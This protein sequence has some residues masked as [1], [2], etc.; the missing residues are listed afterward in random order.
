MQKSG[1]LDTMADIIVDTMGALL[2]SIIG[3]LYAKGN[4]KFL[5]F[6][7]EDFIKA[8]PQIFRKT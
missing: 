6:F 5:R 2:I 4:L 8:N 7:E 1:L 3:F